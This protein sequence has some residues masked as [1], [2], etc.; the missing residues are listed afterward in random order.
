MK[1]NLRKYGIIAFL[2]IFIVI[3]FSATC[4]AQSEEEMRALRLFYDDKDLVVSSTRYPKP[5]SQVAE[6]ITV[7]TADDIDAMNAHTVAEVLNRVPGLFI[8]FNRDFG[9]Y[10]LINMQG[11]EP[12]HTLVLVDDVP[13]NSINEGSAETVTVPVEIIERI[14]IIKGPA[15]SAWGSSLGGV[16]NIITKPVGKAKKPAGSIRASYGKSNSQDY[17]ADLSGKVGEAGYYIYAGVLESDG[18]VRS[19]FSDNESLYSKMEITFSE[20][21]DAGFS[22]GFSNADTGFGDFPDS[23]LNIKASIQSFMTSPYLNAHISKGLDLRLSAYYFRQ[24][25]GQNNNALGLGIVGLPGEI[26]LDT[27]ID[28]ESWG[29]KGQII[30][31]RETHTVVFGMDYEND[32]YDQILNAGTFLQ[33]FGI[34]TISRVIPEN[35]K[36]AIYA[37]DTMTLGKWS[38]TPGIRYDHESVTGSFISPSLGITFAPVENTILRGTIAR[39]FTNPPLSWSAGGAL[40]LD[41]NQLLAP[42][43]VWSYQMGMETAFPYLWVRTN[44]FYHDMED[45]LVRVPFGAGPPAFNDL[46]V[47]QGKITR[48]GFDFDVETEPIFNM[49]FTTGLSYVDINPPTTLGSSETYSCVIGIKYDN[50]NLSGQLSGYYNWYDLNYITNGSYDDFLWDLNI[51]KEIQINKKS[52]VELFFSIHNIFNGFQ[53]SYI[54]YI[55]PRRWLEAGIRFRF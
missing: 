6:N 19:R 47:N 40:F 20:K 15:S 46:F 35:T 1:T 5:I 45:A 21:A 51:N 23:D 25:I 27:A 49:S 38:I 53:Y 14:E 9:A 33:G 50:N 48:K 52:S 11:S 34:P 39:G 37:N 28:E 54:E 26:Y 36:W 2:L 18:L 13:W 42:E 16:I 8:S 10:S 7:I 3:Y 44:L 55:N 12:R 29:G 32:K 43:K 22:I 4:L 31:T 17:R 24:E 30:W 41:P